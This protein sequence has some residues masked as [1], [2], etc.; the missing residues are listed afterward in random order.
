MKI[1]ICIFFL[2]CGA[3]GSRICFIQ[4]DDQ[5]KYAQKH[6][7]V[8]EPDIHLCKYIRLWLYE[9]CYMNSNNFCRNVMLQN[10]REENC[11]R[12]AGSKVC[13]IVAKDQCKFALKSY[14]VQKPD[15]HRCKRLW[16]YELCFIDTDYFCRHVMLLYRKEENCLRAVESEI[17]LKVAEKHCQYALHI[18]PVKYPDMNYCRRLWMYETC[19]INVDNR[20]RKAMRDIRKDKCPGDMPA[21]NSVPCIVTLNSILLAVLQWAIF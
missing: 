10:R 4:A 14:P 12:A 16:M 7:P 6:Y 11:L 19:F 2:I 5:C 9:T 21:D 18:Y 17:C 8:Q 15:I 1:I 13:F 20:C 3:A